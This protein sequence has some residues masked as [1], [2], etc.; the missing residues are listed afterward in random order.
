[1]K[2]FESE[3]NLHS[4]ITGMPVFD[5]EEDEVEKFYKGAGGATILIDDN[6]KIIACVYNDMLDA[7]DIDDL[8]PNLKYVPSQISDF[9]KEH[10]EQSTCIVFGM[11]SSLQFCVFDSEDIDSPN[12]L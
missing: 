9:E 12:S 10:I 3:S 11:M 7:D 8:P 6:D 5:L 1:M 2:L 4:K